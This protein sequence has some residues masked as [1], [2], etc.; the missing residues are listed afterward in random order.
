MSWAGVLLMALSLSGMYLWWPIKRV[1]ISRAARGRRFWFD[2][3]NALGVYALVFLFV[4]ALTGV[5]IGFDSWTTPLLYRVTGS[6]P[7][8]AGCP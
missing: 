7:Y 6:Q 2:V 8:R 3:H 1:S 4:L 5:V